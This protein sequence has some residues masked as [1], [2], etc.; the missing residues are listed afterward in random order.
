VGPFGLVVD[1][2]VSEEHTASIFRAAETLVSTYKLQPKKLL[3]RIEDKSVL[4]IIS[5]AQY[6]KDKG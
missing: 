6:I 4:P 3:L 1:F 5:D 2:S